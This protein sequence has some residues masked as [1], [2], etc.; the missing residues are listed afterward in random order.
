[1]HL[2]GGRESQPSRDDDA[3]D[4]RLGPLQRIH[5]LS[6]RSRSSQLE[7]EKRQLAEACAALELK[8][9]GHDAALIGIIIRE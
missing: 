8:L 6:A 3:Y 1:M 2:H 7:T 5:R 4:D 9:S